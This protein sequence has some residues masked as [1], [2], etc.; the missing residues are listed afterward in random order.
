MIQHFSFAHKG[1]FYHYRLNKQNLEQ[2]KF[3]K[4]KDFL[5]SVTE[6]C[7]NEYFENG[8]RSSSLKFK[9]PC[10]LMQVTNHE[11]SNLTKLGLEHNEERYKTAHT[12]VQVFC[13]ENDMKS[14]AVEIP[15]WFE[16]GENEIIDSKDK[17]TGHIDLLG[18]EDGKV[19]I[20]D[21][22]PGAFKEKYAATQLYFYALMLSKRANLDLKDIRCGYFD[23]AYTFVFDPSKIKMNKLITE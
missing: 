2:V 11:I 17:L 16:D 7:P 12:K 3:D 23:S 13:L 20:W 9:V 5:L 18:Y 22:K 4:L 14:I 8:P 1:G 15:V 21:Y 19:W 10:E 6:T